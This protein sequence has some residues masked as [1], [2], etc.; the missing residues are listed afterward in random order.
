MRKRIPPLVATQTATGTDTTGTS[1]NYGTLAIGS[2]EVGRVVLVGLAARSG[3]VGAT[4]AS[5]TLGGNAGTVLLNAA[6]TAGSNLSLTAFIIFEDVPA[7]TT[8]ELIVTFNDNISVGSAV[9]VWKLMGLQSGAS[10]DTDTDIDGGDATLSL[11]VERG[12]GVFGAEYD[13]TAGTPGWTGIDED[14]QVT[15]PNGG[16]EGSWGNLEMPA[17]DATYSVTGDMSATATNCGCAVVLR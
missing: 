4:V 14:V 10:K 6:N 2:D 3:A 15:V 1:A 17:D 8:A 9:C 7:G 11:N 16:G 12:D 13:D 5:A